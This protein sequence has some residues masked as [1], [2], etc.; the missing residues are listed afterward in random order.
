MKHPEFEFFRAVSVSGT[1][2]DVEGSAISYTDYGV[3][4]GRVW[5][6]QHWEYRLAI[7][8]E[9]EEGKAAALKCMEKPDLVR[10]YPPEDDCW[11]RSQELKPIS[12]PDSITV[13]EPR[14]KIGDRIAERWDKEDDRGRKIGDEYT[15]GIVVGFSYSPSGGWQYIYDQGVDPLMR[16]ISDFVIRNC[17][18][19]FT[20]ERYF[21][22][23]TDE[24]VS[25]RLADRESIAA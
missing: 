12:T 21:L 2:Y 7:T 17:D 16:Q 23:V 11:H 19:E 1:S 24:W 8:G 13:P 5:N 9:G 22:D 25:E 10:E 15:F 4:I 14:F 3:I 6:G 20:P 18:N